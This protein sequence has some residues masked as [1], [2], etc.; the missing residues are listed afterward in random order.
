MQFLYGGS[1]CAKAA[2]DIVA[3]ENPTAINAGMILVFM[4]CSLRRLTAM[5]EMY[6]HARPPT[7]GSQKFAPLRGC[8]LF[9]IVGPSVKAPP[10]AQGSLAACRHSWNVLDGLEHE[11]HTMDVAD[12]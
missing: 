1:A 10:V 5:G 4:A 11:R 9:A 2:K 8:A 12:R 7:G 3:K 6:A